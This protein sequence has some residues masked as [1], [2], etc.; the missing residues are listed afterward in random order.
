MAVY[1]LRRKPDVQVSLLGTQLQQASEFRYLGF[2]V[3]EKLSLPLSKSRILN[4]LN[5]QNFLLQQKLANLPPGY[6]FAVAEYL[7]E[8]VIGSVGIYNVAI[9]GIVKETSRLYQQFFKQVLKLRGSTSAAAVPYLSGFVPLHFRQ[10]G[11]VVKVFSKN[12]KPETYIAAVPG[13]S[14]RSRCC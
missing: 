12:Y 4:N 1:G 10:I 8:A 6:K 13:I 5:A 9:C 2:C 3:N 7:V 14:N 11:A